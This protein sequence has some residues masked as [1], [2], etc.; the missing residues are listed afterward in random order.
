MQIAEKPL[1]PTRINDAQHTLVPLNKDRLD[2]NSKNVSG[3]PGDDFDLQ[4]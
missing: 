1:T 2:G 3:P 4:K